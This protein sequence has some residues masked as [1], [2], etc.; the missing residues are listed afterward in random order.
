MKN[1]IILIILASFIGCAVPVRL[2]QNDIDGKI[3]QQTVVIN[4]IVKYIGDLQD[5]GILPKPEVKKE[6]DK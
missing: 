4:A 1:I 3:S 5:K 6:G 2:E